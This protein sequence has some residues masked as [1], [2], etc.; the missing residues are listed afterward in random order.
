MDILSQIEKEIPL[1]KELHLGHTPM[2][3]E[4]F[5]TAP[6]RGNRKFE[7]LQHLIQMKALSSAVRE[8]W[9]DVEEAQI[10]LES[11]SWWKFWVRPSRRALQRKRLG[12]KLENLKRK[13]DDIQ[14][15]L[16]GHLRVVL[17]KFGDLLELSEQEIL[18]DEGEYW[19]HRLAGQLAH[20]KLALQHG[21][22][23]GEVAAVAALPSALRSKIWEEAQKLF[24]GQ[25]Q[26]EG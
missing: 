20:A 26:L 24:L 13:L 5:K 12:H 1:L 15:E 18:R 9:F 25:K 21:L 6:Q 17:T 14:V 7:F 3:I 10:D 19:V 8:L 11:C 4:Y 23:A 16:T 2:Q 22:P